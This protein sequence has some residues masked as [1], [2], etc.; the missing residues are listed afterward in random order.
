[1]SIT[2]KNTHHLIQ[3]AKKQQRNLPNLILIHP[4][5]SELPHTFFTT[6]Q[7]HCNSLYIFLTI[8]ELI[9]LKNLKK[10][11]ENTRINPNWDSS[12][13]GYHQRRGTPLL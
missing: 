5:L 2:L 1:V 9:V 12:S 11:L 10:I 8:G 4:S 6:N 7:K 3:L 13:R